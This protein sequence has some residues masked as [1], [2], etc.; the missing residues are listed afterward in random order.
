MSEEKV[1]EAV[2]AQIP[3]AVQLANDVKDAVKGQDVR[4]CVVDFLVKEEVEKR[5]TMLVKALVARKE[6]ET[7][8]RK[9]K[10][11]MLTYDETGKVVT[12]GY[13]KKTA[14]ELKKAK[15]SLARIDKAITA[16]INEANY[17]GLKNVGGGQ[18][19]DSGEEPK[20]EQSA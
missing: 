8:V 19:A 20:E 15:E 5:K 12:S 13:T 4:G 9:V 11:D 10:P 7:A 17:D 1:Q 6:A 2:A 14:D 16:A 18:K 3:V